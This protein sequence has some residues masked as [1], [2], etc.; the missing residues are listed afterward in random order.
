MRTLAE[1]A[2]ELR[3]TCARVSQAVKDRQ[4]DEQLREAAAEL[5]DA[6]AALRT[7]AMR[8]LDIGSAL[9]QAAQTRQKVRDAASAIK[10][11][12]SIDA[13]AR[14]TEMKLA[15]LQ[16]KN[17][18][19]A[20]QKDIDAEKRRVAGHFNSLKRIAQLLGDARA[21][22][23]CVTLERT[24]LAYFQSAPGLSNYEDVVAALGQASKLY[25]SLMGRLGPHAEAIREF[26][27]RASANDGVPLSELTV[28]LLQ[29][30]RDA[31][32][33]ETLRVKRD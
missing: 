5:A 17:A 4:L 3:E 10:C 25:D 21:G 22:S 16:T 24:A 26:F 27:E 9:G 18:A 30:I 13:V 2:A 32:L 28:G 14:V 12:V 23:Q 7:S 1:Q 20:L 15:T 33:A 19:E 29:A 31:G 11:P 6:N 8:V